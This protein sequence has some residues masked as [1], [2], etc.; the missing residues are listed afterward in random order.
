MGN[1]ICWGNY[2]NIFY[3]S[4][5]Q[6]WRN[7]NYG[8]KQ[9]VGPS[10]KPFFQTQN[11][12]HQPLHQDGTIKLEETLN[13]FMQVSLTYQKNTKVDDEF[14]CVSL[15]PFSLEGKVQHLYEASFS[16]LKT[17]ATVDSSKGSPSES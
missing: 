4:F 2:N 15:F 1:Q 14:L 11:Q 8:W 16:I 5:N 7:N 9:E 17:L 6:G 10:N 13:H 12:Q 3:H